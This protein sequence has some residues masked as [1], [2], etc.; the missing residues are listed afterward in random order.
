MED[1]ITIFWGFQALNLSL[2]CMAVEE[3]NAF[4]NSNSNGCCGFNWEIVILYSN[5]I[6]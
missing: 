1:E 3:I 5:P 4:Q 2:F 6:T